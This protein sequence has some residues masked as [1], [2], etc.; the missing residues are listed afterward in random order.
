M[1]VKTS[2]TDAI[3]MIAAN[4]KKKTSKPFERKDSAEMSVN[5]GYTEKKEIHNPKKEI[6]FSPEVI[7]TETLHH[8]NY[9]MEEKRRCWYNQEDF[10]EIKKEYKKTVVELTKKKKS[11][12]TP[13]ERWYNQEDFVHIKKECKQTVELTKKKKS[14]GIPKE[15]QE[16]YCFR[17]LEN[18][19]YARALA[20]KKNQQ[21]ARRAVFKEQEK[22]R[23]HLENK[24]KEQLMRDDAEEEAIATRYSVYSK[25]CALEAYNMGLM[26][27]A[28]AFNG[29]NSKQEKDYNETKTRRKK[30]HQQRWV[31]IFSSKFRQHCESFKSYSSRAA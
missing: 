30:S 20:R 19:M 10:V 6:S 12:V 5:N 16:E 7:M 11:D 24:E 18:R 14:D 27:E 23:Q 1:I 4:S 22:R 8:K 15:Q 28:E 13:E 9:T 29:D 21:K 25:H 17:G 3:I 31:S 2:R 26:D